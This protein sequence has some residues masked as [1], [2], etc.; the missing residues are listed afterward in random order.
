M[1][2][3]DATLDD[4]AEACAVLRASIIQLCTADHHDDPD[5][6]SRWLAN[7]TPENVAAWADAKGRSLLV[8]VEDGAIV[9]VGGVKDSGEITVNYVAPRARFRGVSAALLAALEL[10]AAERG[11]QQATLL[12]T[13]TAHHFYLARGY[14]V[15]G[16]PQSK[17]GTTA[18]YPMA[19]ALAGAGP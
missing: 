12:S 8:A 19:K 3:R 14:Q 15:T 18:S 1:I 13:W 2:I 4:A 10:R 7:K 17:F 9:A 11:A 6:L 16:P 5:I